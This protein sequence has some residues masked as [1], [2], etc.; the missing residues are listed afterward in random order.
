MNIRNVGVFCGARNEIAEEFRLIA[1]ETAALIAKNNLTLVYGG[2]SSGLMGEISETARLN[3][4]KVLG[5]YPKTLD[6]REPL[7]PN[8]DFAYVVDTMYERKE[9]MIDKSDAFIIL[10]GGVGTLDEAFEVITLKIIGAHD[11]P[12]LFINHNNYWSIIND[13][14]KHV[15]DHKFAASNIFDTYRFVSNPEEAFK[16][17][18]F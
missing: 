11:K 3:G 12:I 16:K 5:V 17:L 1:R 4:G 15:V 9:I 6:A 2:T 13:L 14:I 18:G 7:N 8:L 10:P